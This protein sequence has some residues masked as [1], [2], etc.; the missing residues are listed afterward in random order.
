[1]AVRMVLTEGGFFP[2]VFHIVTVGLHPAKPE[3]RRAGYLGPT[4]TTWTSPRSCG[5]SSRSSWKSRGEGPKNEKPK[6]PHPVACTVG[7][8]RFFIPGGNEEERG[9]NCPRS[10]LRP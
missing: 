6:R 9:Q 1:L 3:G 8:E 2:K 5:I 10:S 7:W 4:T